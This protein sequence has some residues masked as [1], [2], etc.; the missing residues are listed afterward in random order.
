MAAK[1]DVEQE[2][3]AIEW[4]EFLTGETITDFHGSL[5]DGVILCKLL[6]AIKPNTVRQFTLNPKNVLAERVSLNFNLN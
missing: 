5:K 2:R 4:I 1:Y 6:N 3:K